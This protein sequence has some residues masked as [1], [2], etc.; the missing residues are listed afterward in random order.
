MR[1]INLVLGLLVILIFAAACGS[2][3]EV[4]TDTVTDVSLVATDIAFNVTR[5][6]V[7]ANQAVRL[8][9]ENS[10]A[11]EHDFSIREIDV[12]DVH[13]AEGEADDHAMSE[14][15]HELDLHVAAL[16]G[17]GRGTLEFTPTEPGEYEYYCTV[18]GHK[19]AGMLGTLVVAP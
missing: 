7:P 14:D 4:S 15:V 1:R 8:T 6:E 11:L 5:L 12:R 13:T 18:P 2:S 10:G 16:P 17:G 3:P 19:E 9:L